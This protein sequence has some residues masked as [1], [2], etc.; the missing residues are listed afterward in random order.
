MYSSK[1]S[2]FPNG[3]ALRRFGVNLANKLTIDGVE[4]TGGGGAAPKPLS[5][6]TWR[7]Y[8][9]SITALGGV[10]GWVP[11]VATDQ[12]MSVT[13]RGQSGW[14]INGTG[15]GNG[16]AEL[17]TVI[18]NP[19]G[20]QVITFTGGSNH[21]GTTN[22]GS[23]ND[24]TLATV[25]G[26]LNL[27]AKWCITNNAKLIFLT[28]IQYATDRNTGNTKSDGVKYARQAI[29][30]VALKYSVSVLDWYAIS[31]ITLETATKYTT[32]GLHPNVEGHRIMASH[33]SKYI[34]NLVV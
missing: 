15:A 21:L 1:G 8:G 10:S 28:P 34:S 14:I 9:D 17:L 27:V 7:S 4:Q 6:K 18:D 11:L 20:V 31:G 33:L 32:D 3:A 22:L 13:N 23:I 24:N 19:V 16:I 29:L 30:D 26:S 25:Y 5:G 2:S 12:G